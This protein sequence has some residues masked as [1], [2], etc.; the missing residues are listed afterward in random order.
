MIWR[1]TGLLGKIVARKYQGPASISLYV[2]AP[3]SSYHSHLIC[4]SYQEE[5]EG[6]GYFL[7]LKTM[8]EV[9]CGGSHL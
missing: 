2:A 7:P 1:P 8:Y 6:R 4:Y 3:P 9:G 5:G